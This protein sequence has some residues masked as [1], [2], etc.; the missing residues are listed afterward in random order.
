[1]NN[2]N[3]KKNYYN[4]AHCTTEGLCVNCNRMHTHSVSSKKGRSSE[5]KTGQQFKGH[6][7]SLPICVWVVYFSIGLGSSM[8]L[9]SCSE[10]KPDTSSRKKKKPT[11]VHNLFWEGEELVVRKRAKEEHMDLF[12]TQISPT[13]KTLREQRRWIKH[14]RDLF[15]CECRC[16]STHLKEKREIRRR[17]REWNPFNYIYSTLVVLYLFY[18]SFFFPLTLEQ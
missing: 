12:V 7:Q 5:M 10:R 9:V 11:D 13:W 16:L 14:D 8:K 2:N 1:M 3:K 4:S 6:F 17:V 18:S 15:P